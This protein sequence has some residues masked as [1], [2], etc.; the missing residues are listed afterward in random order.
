M[1][2]G[3]RLRLVYASVISTLL[4]GCESWILDS[5]KPAI[6]GRTIPG[7]ARE[8][9]LDVMMR[10]RDR[11]CLR[12]EDHRVVRRVLLNCIWRTLDSLFGDVPDQDGRKAAEIA[13]VWEKWKSSG[14]QSVAN[15]FMGKCCEK[16]VFQNITYG[17]ISAHTSTVWHAFSSPKSA[18]FNFSTR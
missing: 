1:T 5:A 10:A 6:A 17:S 18:Y 4:Y 16:I 3:L 7:E 2:K 9:T 15:L 14:L 11:Q 8:P 13:A 12:R